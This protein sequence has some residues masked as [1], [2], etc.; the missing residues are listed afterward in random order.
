VSGWIGWVG[1]VAG[2]IALGVQIG[3]TLYERGFDSG[4]LTGAAQAEINLR[5][6]QSE[7]IADQ[8][9][10]VLAERRT[11]DSTSFADDVQPGRPLPP[12]QRERAALEAAIATWPA[13]PETCSW[14]PSILLDGGVTLNVGA[15]GW[16]LCVDRH[17]RLS[18]QGFPLFLQLPGDR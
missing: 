17:G 7:A 18:T 15:K 5:S 1:A 2:A 6:M 3:R 16:A 8:V 4:R 10:A 14:S 11:G 13:L 9:R 12:F